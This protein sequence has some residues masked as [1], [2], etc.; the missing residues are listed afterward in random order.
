MIQVVDSRAVVVDTCVRHVTVE[1]KVCW[2]IQ[3][4]P[5]YRS[6]RRG[7]MNTD[8]LVEVNSSTKGNLRGH[9]ET[10]PWPLSRGCLGNRLATSC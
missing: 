4:L 8:A 5:T 10:T 1:A 6:I 9:P 7:D 3:Y 2:N